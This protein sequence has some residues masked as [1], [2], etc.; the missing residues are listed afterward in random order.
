M[1]QITTQ[2]KL[3]VALALMLVVTAFVLPDP[4]QAQIQTTQ[5]ASA[6]FIKEQTFLTSAA[7]TASGNSGTPVDLSAYDVGVIVVN[8]TAVSGTS[9][10]LTVNFQVCQDKAGTICVS[11]TATS[12]LTTTGTTLLKVNQYG[13]YANISYT[14]GGTTPSFTFSVYGAF[15]P[16]T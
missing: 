13:R 2:L 16:T 8:I 12:S 15:K 4:A 9:P 11:H 14:I 10:T 7:R 1:K 5:D 6:A 3:A